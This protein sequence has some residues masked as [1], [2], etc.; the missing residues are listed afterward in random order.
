MVLNWTA[1]ADFSLNTDP[2]PWKPAHT[3]KTSYLKFAGVFLGFCFTY[4]QQKPEIIFMYHTKNAGVCKAKEC[5]IHPLKHLRVWWKPGIPKSLKGYNP[6]Y[7]T[8]SSASQLMKDQDIFVI[9]FLCLL[10]IEISI[11]LIAA[12]ISQSS[13][14]AV[15]INNKLC[16]KQAWWYLT[17]IA[18]QR[19]RKT[20]FTWHYRIPGNIPTVLSALSYQF[21]FLHLFRVK[22]SPSP[23][24]SVTSKIFYF[25]IFQQKTHSVTQLPD[26]M[27]TILRAD[28]LAL[29]YL[30]TCRCSRCAALK[31]GILK[32]DWHTQKKHRT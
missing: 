23:F 19:F 12:N 31:M 10:D 29:C 2:S 18:N 11:K 3:Y 14:V 4:S 30:E 17:A 32:N 27:L 7:S 21:S 9:V 1:A 8:I 25:P 26:M 15:L 28:R 16:C 5:L 13:E 24:T 6:P 20:K 22:P